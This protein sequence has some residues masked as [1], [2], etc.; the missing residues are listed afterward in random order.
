MCVFVC[1]FCQLILAWMFTCF[2][3]VCLVN[4]VTCHVLNIE[5]R[6]FFHFKPEIVGSNSEMIPPRRSLSATLQ[7]SVVLKVLL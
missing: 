7:L 2:S 3:L 4:I 6:D 1:V 5:T